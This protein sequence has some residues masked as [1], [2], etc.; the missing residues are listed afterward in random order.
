M[1]PRQR[2]TDYDGAEPGAGSVATDNLLRLAGYVGGEEGKSL[3]RKA[4]EHLAAAFS[5]P[6]TPQAFPELAAS[7]A[8]GIL[9]PK[10]V[11]Q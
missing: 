4:A 9:G 8:T 7:L 3:R 1:K 11:K 2:K 10:Q 5:L 6:E